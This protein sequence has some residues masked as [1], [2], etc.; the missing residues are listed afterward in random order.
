MVKI[1]ISLDLKKRIDIH[2]GFIL[3]EDELE[4]WLDYV[5]KT[6]LKVMEK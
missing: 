1:N 2:I 5:I 4:N 3:N 6:H